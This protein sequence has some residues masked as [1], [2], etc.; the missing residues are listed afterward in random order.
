MLL[1]AVAM[2]ATA[3]LYVWHVDSRPG[4]LDVLTVGL[5]A[6]VIYPLFYLPAG[7][8][9]GTIALLARRSDRHW[10][11]VTSILVA[12]AAA[13]ALTSFF[14]THRTPSIYSPQVMIFG[15]SVWIL[16]GLGALALFR[17][18]PGRSRQ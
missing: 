5:F 13:G 11:L 9:V 8:V 17:P 3:S 7:L 2:F 12:S 1:A 15:A 18:A 6:V 10:L 4:I 14:A 16:V